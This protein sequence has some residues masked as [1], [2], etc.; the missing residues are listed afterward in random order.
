MFN[1]WY[2][3]KDCQGMMNSK[4]L[5]RDLRKRITLPQEAV[6]TDTM[7]YLML[8]SI[9]G[10]TRSDVI[11]QKSVS[12]TSAESTKLNEGLDRINANEPIQYI[13]GSAHFY[14]REFQ[15]NSAV[16]IPRPETE[17]I[18]AEVLRNTPKT[19]GKI[20]DIGTG[21]GCIAV[22]LAKELPD[23]TI[24]A[25]DVSDAAL[26]IASFNA[27]HLQ[28]DVLFQRVDILNDEIQLDDLECIVSNPPYVAVSE[29]STMNANVLNHEPH[30]ALFVP[31]DDPLI[32][33]T[34]IAKKGINA[35]KPGGKI[36]VEINEQFGKEVRELFIQ[37]GF[38]GAIVIKDLQHKD[39]IVTAV[40]L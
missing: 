28:A 35:L 12:L 10:L 23:K 3:C 40:K 33:Y 39:R 32:F 2:T 24:I 25:Y 16:L 5:F 36:V 22:T 38:T 7:V 31:D 34:M 8:E 13:L 17:L 6:E 20:L 26:K 15:V 18:V 37:T 1:N 14:G 27:S 9:A 30:L 19:P 21:S 29:K 11:A 4:D